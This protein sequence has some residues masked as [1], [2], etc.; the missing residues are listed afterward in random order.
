MN[1]ES[2]EGLRAAAKRSAFGAA[3]E[4]RARECAL[5]FDAGVEREYERGRQSGGPD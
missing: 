4:L 3:F 2:R 1:G 5:I